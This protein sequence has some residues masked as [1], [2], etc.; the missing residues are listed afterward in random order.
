MQTHGVVPPISTT[1]SSAASINDDVYGTTHGSGS[2]TD[3]SSHEET[4][5]SYMS[6]HEYDMEDMQTPLRGPQLHERP[7]LKLECLSPHTMRKSEMRL[8]IDLC[9]TVMSPVRDIWNGINGQNGNFPDTADN[10]Q[11]P[12]QIVVNDENG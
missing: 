11:Y 10:A 7:T 4:D 12:F 3:D 5:V 2:E 6:D 1:T 9:D 8:E